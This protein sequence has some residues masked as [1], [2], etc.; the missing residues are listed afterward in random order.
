MSRRRLTSFIPP[1]SLE[2]YVG[3]D[4][5]GVLRPLFDNG[6]VALALDERRWRKIGNLLS[7]VSQSKSP[8]PGCPR[9]AAA[10]R[11]KELQGL[12]IRRV[13]GEDAPST[14]GPLVPADRARSICSA[15]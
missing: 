14:G 15:R 10:A 5:V 8:R 12:G 11:S 3:G 9:S 2:A 1:T 7:R 4:Q 6:L 13:L